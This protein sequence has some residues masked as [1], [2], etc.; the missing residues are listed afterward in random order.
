MK[1]IKNLFM[2]KCPHCNKVLIN[3][4]S[5]MLNP[6]VIKSCP[7]GHYEK[8]YHSALESVIEKPKY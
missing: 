4:T 6:I 5:S 1:F 8:E 7:D 2:D 3:S